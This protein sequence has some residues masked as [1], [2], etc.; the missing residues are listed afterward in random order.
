ML[1]LSLFTLFA[2]LTLDNE[3]SLFF[4]GPSNKTPETRKW[5]R[6]WL[7]VRDGTGTFLA[8][9]SRACAL[10]L[11]NLKKKRDCSQSN[12]KMLLLE[13]RI[14]RNCSSVGCQKCVQF[15]WISETW[16]IGFGS[17]KVTRPSFFFLGG[18]GVTSSFE[19]LWY[20]HLYFYCK[21]N[22]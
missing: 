19:A 14:S 16:A 6:A 1:L 20:P 18:G 3:Q 4:L 22:I 2:S 15:N 9:L 13:I 7:K 10:P 5:P 12:G 21:S 17:I 8:Q 11:L